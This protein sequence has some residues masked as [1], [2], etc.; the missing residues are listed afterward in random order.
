MFSKIIL[1]HSIEKF[2]L[3]IVS[4][5]FKYFIKDRKKKLFDYC[6]RLVGSYSIHKNRVGA[7]NDYFLRLANQKDKYHEK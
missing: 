2:D 3:I 1:Q 4:N 6:Q 5:C 7:I